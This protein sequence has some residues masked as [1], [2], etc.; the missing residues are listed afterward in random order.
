MCAWVV[1]QN[2][3][4]VILSCHPNKAHI[5][6]TKKP[7]YAAVYIQLCDWLYIRFCAH[8]KLF[9]NPTYLD[10][11]LFDYVRGKSG[12]FFGIQGKWYVA[13]HWFLWLLHINSRKFCPV[14][15]LLLTD[16]EVYDHAYTS[17]WDSWSVLRVNLLIWLRSFRSYI[18]G[19]TID[20]D[21]VYCRV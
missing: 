13:R 10:S 9:R 6:S 3:Y 15:W 18:L 11:H 7:G 5:T 21:C 2:V 4:I 19:L 14:V 8:H 16:V 20:S 1:V 12:N 17:L